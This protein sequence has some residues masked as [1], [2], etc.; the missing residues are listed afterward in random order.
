MVQEQRLLGLCNLACHIGQHEA[1]DH[2]KHLHVALLVTLMQADA[3]D[4]YIRHLYGCLAKAVEL[5]APCD[6]RWEQLGVSPD[7]VV[8]ISPI[9]LLVAS[10]MFHQG[11]IHL[12]INRQADTS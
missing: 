4:P 3:S 1:G 11:L 5:V 9:D 10:L 6:A 7:A 2:L 12:L 8:E